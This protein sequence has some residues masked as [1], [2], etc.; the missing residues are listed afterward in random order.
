MTVETGPK[1]ST[2]WMAV[3]AQRVVG[4]EDDRVEEGALLGV[5]GG[6]ADLVGVAGD[7]L[8]FLLQLADALAHLLAL[9]EAGERRPCGSPR[10]TGR[11]GWSSPGGRRGRRRA[12][13]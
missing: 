10:S 2:S 4:V 5:A 11:R 3:L 13:R 12:R 6:D 9:V 1:A 8:G 7:D